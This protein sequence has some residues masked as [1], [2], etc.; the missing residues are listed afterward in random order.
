MNITITGN[1]GSGKSTVCKEFQ[2]YGYEII[3]TGDIFRNIALS[4]QMSVLELN[5]Q[6]KK[7]IQEGKHSIDDEIDGLTTKIG[8]EKDNVVFDSRLAW[9]FV[10]DSFKV[11]LTVDINTAAKRVFEANR[12]TERFE[13][14]EECKSKLLNRQFIE[15]DR[16]SELYKIDYYNMNNYNLIIDSS[17]V[18]PE[19]IVEEIKKQLELFKNKS[20][21]NKLL[22]NPQSLFPT[23]TIRDIS[24]ERLMDYIDDTKMDSFGIISV[25]LKNNEW[26]VIDGHHRTIAAARNHISFIESEVTPTFVP[27]IPLSQIYDYED[28]SGFK[29]N[30]YPSNLETQ[31]ILSFPNK[32]TLSNKQTFEN[33]ILEAKKIL[34]TNKHKKKDHNLEER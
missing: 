33:N 16:F 29:F 23:Q 17:N 24:A 30:Y 20:F 5:E 18:T 10:E 14:I 8:K 11:F 34:S 27:A 9:H 21:N 1:L 28:A 12:E 15:R 7:E 25:A 13:N 3:S 22:I 32:D 19:I 6:I 2:K 26:Y 31:N 4:K